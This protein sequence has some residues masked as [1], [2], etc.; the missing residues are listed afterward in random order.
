MKTPECFFL[1]KTKRKLTTTQEE[2]IR[3]CENLLDGKQN[4]PLSDDIHDDEHVM[5]MEAN[6]I[7]AE[8]FDATCRKENILEF[9]RTEIPY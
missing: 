1:K 2:I 7:A 9:S 4:P 8:L 3:N 5:E 6:K